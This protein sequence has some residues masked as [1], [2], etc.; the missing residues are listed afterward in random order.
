MTA[1]FGTVY[2]RDRARSRPSPVTCDPCDLG[3]TVTAGGGA[4]PTLL[5]PK[6]AGRVSLGLVCM[7]PEFHAQ[8]RDQ[9][10]A[11]RHHVLGVL[12]PKP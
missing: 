5:H 8:R 11:V 10:V 7:P 2:P 6:L 12:V 9:P 1:Q 3:K 4:C